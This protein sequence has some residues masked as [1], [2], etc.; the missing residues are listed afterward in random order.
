MIGAIRSA[1]SV[2]PVAQ[3]TAVLEDLE[4]INQYSRTYHHDQN[5]GGAD[6][7]PIN[8]GELSGYVRKALDLVGGF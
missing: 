8:D 5:P 1:D 7:E 2:S 3:A 4:D 6:T